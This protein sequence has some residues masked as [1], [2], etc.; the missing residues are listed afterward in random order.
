MAFMVFLAV[1]SS[2]ES[3]LVRHNVI[4]ALYVAAV[5]TVEQSRTRKSGRAANSP[6][7]NPL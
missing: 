2:A 1:V 6:P 5:I 3:K 7:R 4:W